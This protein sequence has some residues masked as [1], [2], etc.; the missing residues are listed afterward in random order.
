MLLSCAFLFNKS[1]LVLLWNL[2]SCHHQN[3]RLLH[4]GHASSNYPRICLHNR[5]S[6]RHGNGI[7]PI[8]T[9]RPIPR[10]RFIDCVYRLVDFSR[11]QLPPPLIRSLLQYLIGIGTYPSV[12]LTQSWMNSNI[13]GFTRRYTFLPYQINED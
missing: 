5:I 4:P 11:Q 9:A 7:R 2:P 6:H 10:C 12:I 1:Q 3:I 8:K 13:V